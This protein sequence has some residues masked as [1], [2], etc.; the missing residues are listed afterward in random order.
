MKLRAAWIA[1]AVLAAWLLSPALYPVHVEGFSASIVS[2]GIHLSEGTLA[3]FFPSQPINTEYFGLTKLGAVLGV[4]GLVK[5]G[6]SGEA[7]M[8]LLTLLG[9]ILLAGGSAR[10]IRQWTGAPW[11]LICAVLLLIPGIAESS[12]FFADNM[13]GAGLLVAGL[14]IFAAR[15]GVATALA[16]GLL[17][18]LAITVR[19]DLVLVT[20]AILL[21]AWQR[22]P[23]PRAAAATAIAAIASLTTLWLAFALVGA[24]PLDAIRTGARAVTLWERPGDLWR[25]SLAML[26]F[27]GPPALLLCLLGIRPALAGGRHR[28]ALLLGMP[29]LMNL[30]LAGR[31][32][33]VRQLLPLTPFLASVCVLGAMQLLSEWRSGRRFMPGAVSALI[34]A[35][36]IAPPAIVYVSDGPRAMIGRIA[37]IPLWQ[38]WQAGVRGNFALIDRVIA[39]AP[40][41]ATFA[42]VTDY[43]NE[44]RYLHLRLLEHGYRAVPQS[45]ECD[46]IGQTMAKGDR[47]ILQI[48]PHQT[49]LANAGTLYPA[50]LTQLASPCLHGLQPVLIASSDRVRR[51]ANGIDPVAAWHPDDPELT[52]TVLSPALLDRLGR[53]H[54]LESAND[55]PGKFRTL[56]AA[57][58]ATRAQT[59]FGTR[60]AG[61]R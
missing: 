51:L 56:D 10:L 18:G 23:L 61:R 37:A 12:F 19:T 43:W 46:A 55:P 27:L 59:R 24:S 1:L 6:L 20:P 2:L 9:L 34:A 26:L 60:Q 11:L 29:L 16:T 45:P 49:F 31:I 54:R 58:D 28:A 21:I 33:E 48:S 40:P 4:A 47:T 53:D 13:L 36:L 25:Q 39:S 8:R 30:A 44:D 14:A 42:V 38:Q 41:G 5:L 22:Q 7:A 17:T 50:R 57:R 3:D 35:V 52:A 15:Q 32:W